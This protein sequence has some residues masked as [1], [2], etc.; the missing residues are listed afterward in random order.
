MA[1]FKF[2]RF[3]PPSLLHCCWDGAV[4]VV[5]TS[6]AEQPT[7]RGSIPGTGDFSFLRRIQTM[8]PTQPPILYRLGGGKRSGREPDHLPPS[9]WGYVWLEPHLCTHM[10]LHGVDRD[11]STFI[12]N[13]STWHRALNCK[14]TTFFL[15][16][17]SGLED[18]TSRQTNITSPSCS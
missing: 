4:P 12:I 18:D 5:T 9:S 10:C 8:G 2:L 6:Q 3:S 1:A 16:H 15:K 13:K 11:N 7:I 17:T 14:P